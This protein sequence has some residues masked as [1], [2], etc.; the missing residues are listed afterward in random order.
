MRIIFSRDRPAQLDLLLHSIEKNMIEDDTRILWY[1]SSGLYRRGYKRVTSQPMQEEGEYAARLR[2]LLAEGPETVTFFCDD[3]IVFRP[4]KNNPADALK[5]ERVICHNLSL[6]QGNTKMPL[7]AGFPKWNWTYLPAHDF[8]FPCS[9]N[10]VT[11]RT[12]T[13]LEMLGDR[14]PENPTWT[15]TQMTMRLRKFKRQWPMMCSEQEQCLVSVAVNRTSV[16]AG[17]P[18]GRVFPQEPAKLASRFLRGQ[19]IDLD[20]IDFS[21]VDSVHHEFL[22]EWA[23]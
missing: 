18:A 23:A 12:G 19:H 10:G 8:G 11:Y 15:E 1:A 14:D 4:V 13:F 21:G 9:L 17:A 7:P 3:D 22:Y 5:D 2:G 20:K 6:G 16:T